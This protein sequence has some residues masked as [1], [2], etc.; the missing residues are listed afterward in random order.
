MPL[1]GLEAW[2]EAYAEA[3]Y[4]RK[5]AKKVAPLAYKQRALQMRD[6]CLVWWRAWK[7]L[8]QRRGV[9]AGI[10]RK[11]MQAERHALLLHRW[12]QRALAAK[13]RPPRLMELP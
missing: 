13:R 5:V 12:R 6:A 10:A 3:F 8:A 2:F 7:L 1:Q 9:A 4:A 11:L